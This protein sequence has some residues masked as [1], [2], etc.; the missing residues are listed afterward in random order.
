MAPMD[1]KKPAREAELYA[2]VKLWLTER[3]Y[4]VR[5]EVGP[6]D[7][8][9]CHSD[10]RIAV[11]ELKLGFSLALFHQA[12]ARLSV[13]DDVW[14]AVP[15]PGRRARR[16]NLA[17]A[18]R[19]GVGILSVR[20]RDAHVEELCAPGAGLPRKSAKKAARLVRSH[21]RLRGD[22]NTG[23]ATRHGLVTGYRM[24]AIRCARFL[25]M[26]GPSRGA[27]VAHRAAVP[28]ATRIMA[29]NHYGWFQRP[30]RG[31]YDLTDAGR[32]GLN[33]YGDVEV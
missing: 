25:A 16:D 2:P 21:A 15:P 30:R 22:P 14:L 17:L 24:D 26:H 9:G 23:G 19:L 8:V 20:L 33:D 6:A 5:A 29:D 31:V 28:S 18:R 11:V 12:V 3:G 32:S 13:T 1:P 4:D 27:V 10:G 7:V